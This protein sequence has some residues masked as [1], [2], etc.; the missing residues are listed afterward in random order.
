MASLEVGSSS[1]NVSDDDLLFDLIQNF[2]R[3][4]RLFLTSVFQGRSSPTE[5][6]KQGLLFQID[7]MQVV[8][9]NAPTGELRTLVEAF[10]RDVDEWR[11][12]RQTDI[13]P[14]VQEELSRLQLQH[15]ARRE[16]NRR[17]IEAFEAEMNRISVQTLQNDEARSFSEELLD[18][19]RLNIDLAQKRIA[20]AQALIEATEPKLKAE[21]ENL[22]GLHAIGTWLEESPRKGMLSVRNLNLNL[23]K[24]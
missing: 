12:L 6:L 11:R 2:F 13:S 20:S 5:S 22:L 9:G 3:S 16:E 18:G 1:E 14:F 8:D 15:E 17:Q 7:S 10:G 23:P 24:N 4:M 21:A 19:Y